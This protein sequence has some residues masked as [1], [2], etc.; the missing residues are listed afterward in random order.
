M[1]LQSFWLAFYLLGFYFFACGLFVVSQCILSSSLSSSSSSCS[2]G[3]NEVPLRSISFILGIVIFCGLCNALLLIPSGLELLLNIPTSLALLLHKLVIALLVAGTIVIAMMGLLALVHMYIGPIKISLNPFRGFLPDLLFRHLDRTVLFFFS[4]ATAAYFLSSSAGKYLYDTGLYHLPFVTH[5]LNYGLEEGMA[6][7]HARYA[8]YNI[9][10]FGQ[11]PLQALAFSPNIVSPSLNILFFVAFLLAAYDSINAVF[12]NMRTSSADSAAVQRSSAN[13]AQIST[14]SYWVLVF[15][16]GVGTQYSLISFDADFAAA[17][18]T[19]ILVFRLYSA[20]SSKTIR[21]EDLL[22]AACLPLLKLSGLVSVLFASLFLIF[23]IVPDFLM[24]TYHFSRSKLSIEHLYSNI[25]HHRITLLLLGFFYSLFV[26][27]S[28]LQSGYAVFPQY[29]TGPIGRHALPQSR[30]VEIKDVFITGWA[31]YQDDVRREVKANPPLSEWLPV[32]ISSSRGKQILFMIVTSFF[33]ALC[34]GIARVFSH[35]SSYYRNLLAFSLATGFTSTLILLVLPPDIRFYS[36]IK[37]FSYFNFAEFLLISPLAGFLAASALLMAI[38]VMFP[39][40]VAR[41]QIPAFQSHTF[42]ADRHQALWKSR[43]VSPH[44][45]VR[46][47]KPLVGDQCWNAPPPCSPDAESLQG[48]L[49][50]KDGHQ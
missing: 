42:F 17:I 36:W 37:A 34:S 29:Q 3:L 26:F 43:A 15:A 30:V 11:V 8:F 47:A 24:G 41:K 1:D 9:Q 2:V 40:V 35:S 50:G 39:G 49:S 48:A 16:F 28:V 23:L 7:L 19:S 31:R 38:D 22:L 45:L 27:T 10:L 12:S 14:I 21:I 5:L 32:F 44:S 46:V 33:V 13:V 4:L 18:V 25:K 20:A 6:H